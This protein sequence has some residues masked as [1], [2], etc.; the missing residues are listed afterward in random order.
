MH[1]YLSTA[2]K[3]AQSAGAIQQFYRGSD[4]DIST[5]S[6]AIDLVTKVDKL[7]ESKIRELILAEYPDH[8]ILGEEQGQMGESSYR[9][10]VDPLDGTLN[11]AHG[12]PYYCVSIALEIG[13]HIEVAVIFDPNRDEL[14]S[15]IRGQGAF[16]N[17]VAMAVSEE[18]DFS[19][20]MLAT[21]FSYD[22][23][24]LKKN[25]KLFAKVHPQV[26]AIRRPGAAALD[27]AYV[28]CGR[29][30]AFWELS[31]NPWDV[32]AGWLIIQEAGGSV[33][34]HQGQ[35]Y[36]VDLPIVLASNGRLQAKLVHALGLGDSLA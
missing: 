5:K 25:L 24:E 21:G 17:G 9:W 26:R 18:T 35:P 1:T 13:G 19:K 8:V 30:D 31:L 11:Y 14:F 15:A 7:C 4:L 23:Q 33:T 20:A 32:A 36:R 12:F 29:L 34:G 28:A 27:L 3:A 6:S 10:I 22:A 16:C 2:I